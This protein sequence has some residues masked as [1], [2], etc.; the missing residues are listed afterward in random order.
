MDGSDPT[1]YELNYIWMS[2]YGM[3][4]KH[5]NC[6]HFCDA[7]CLEV[8]TADL[9][10][11]QAQAAMV[12]ACND[13]WTTTDKSECSEITDADCWLNWVEPPV[14]NDTPL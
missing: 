13:D 10:I 14:T 12:M 3:G 5:Y 6:R 7:L 4:Y 1:C 2:K 8:D 9:C 11:E